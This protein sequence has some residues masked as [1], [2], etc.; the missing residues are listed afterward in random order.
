MEKNPV[1]VQGQCEAGGLTRKTVPIP[2]V[3]LPT[4]VNAAT[5]LPVP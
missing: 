1:D 4:M 2:R 3:P 5:V